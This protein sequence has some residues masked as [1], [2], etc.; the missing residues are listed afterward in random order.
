MGQQRVQISQLR[1][2]SRP[3]SKPVE[4]VVYP[5]DATKTDSGFT[6]S[7]YKGTFETL[8]EQIT[9]GGVSSIRCHDTM[10]RIY[11]VENGYCLFIMIDKST[12]SKTEVI[13]SPSKEI[14]V[15]E[16]FAHYI[17]GHVDFITNIYVVQGKCFLDDLVEEANDQS[18]IAP[19]DEAV[20][21]HTPNVKIPKKRSKSKA[22]DQSMKLAAKK[23]GNQGNAGHTSVMSSLADLMGNTNVRADNQRPSVLSAADL[24]PSQ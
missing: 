15:P 4:T 13:G 1:R 16:G 18:K 20:A 14:L 12:G 7:G 24:R 11:R 10:P 2:R 22:A 21:N 19:F 6:V 17:K 5:E 3:K 8:S 23:P 9:A